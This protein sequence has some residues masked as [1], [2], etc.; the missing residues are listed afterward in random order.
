MEL[1]SRMKADIKISDR[2]TSAASS[3]WNVL[4]RTNQPLI[5]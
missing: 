3:D 5:G 4:I 2:N 1:I